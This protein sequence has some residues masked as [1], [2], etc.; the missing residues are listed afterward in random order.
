MR[1]S[2]ASRTSAVVSAAAS[3]VTAVVGAGVTAGFAGLHTYGFIL[4]LM[5]FAPLSVALWIG[6]WVCWHR[7]RAEIR[8][9]GGR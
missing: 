7:A 9:L 6:V 1:N 5:L 8:R 2:H 4:L 3:A